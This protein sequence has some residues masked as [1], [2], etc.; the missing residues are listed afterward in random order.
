MFKIKAEESLLFREREILRIISRF[1]EAKLKFIVV[2]GYAVA[3]SRHRFSIDLD[4]VIAERE[5]KVFEDLLTRSG[6]SLTYSKELALVY[7]EKFK[8][9]G[10]RIEGFP[11]NVDLLING[12]VSRTTDASWGFEYIKKES[13]KSSLNGAEF[14]VPSRE[15]LIAMKIH[16]G[17]F[18]DIRDIAALIE[19]S[20]FEAIK[21]HAVRGNKAKL[22]KILSRGIEFLD[23]SS[24]PDS[25]KGVFGARVYKKELVQR[26]KNDMIKLKKLL[27]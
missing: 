7:G 18:S 13:G 20:D 25:F 27:P 6:Y 3:T 5:C 22:K 21:N 19:G 15:L 17:R 2:G 24:F 26:A 4:I 14:F 8:R 12:L 16:S 11:V 1:L 9:F 23:S 10:K